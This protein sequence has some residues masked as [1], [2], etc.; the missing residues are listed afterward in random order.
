V[1]A[2]SVRLGGPAAAKPRSVL[3]SVAVPSEHGGWGLTL[4]PALLGLLIAPT[5]AGAFLAVAAM[6]AFL[7]RT[8]LKVV[9]VDRRRGRHLERTTVAGVVFA[10]ELTV[11]AALVVGA[12]VLADGAFWVPALVAAP[13]VVLELWFDMRSRSRRT[14]PEVA[15]SVGICAVAA[16]I[17]LADGEGARL[18][19]AVWV[20]LAAR[21]VTAIPF[22]RAQ[23]ARLHNRPVAPAALL[24]TDAA[25]LAAA[26]IAVVVEPSVVGGAVAVLAIVV[27]Q[28][29]T[30]RGPV[31]RPAVLGVRQL[32]LGLAVVAATAVGVQVA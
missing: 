31:P 2:P 23:I 15:G 9:L 12:V 26:A 29:L 18:A 7:A 27:I 14:I 5:V 11:T 22:V 17:V 8:P 32:A 28:R 16:M 13:L 25:A 24:A 19:A 10:V 3:R 1:T 4:E 21:A 6:L 20:V 30:A